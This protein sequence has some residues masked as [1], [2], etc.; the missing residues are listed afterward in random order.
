MESEAPLGPRLPLPPDR[1]QVVILNRIPWAQYDALCRAR[2]DSAGPRMAYLDGRL[3]FISPSR[4]HEYEKKLIAR[5]IETYAEETGLS[6]N[7]FGSETYRRKVKEA[8]V[9]PD[10]CYCVGPAKLVPDFAIAVEYT[11]GGIDKLEI[12]RRLR[13]AE[14]WIWA[15]GRFWIYRLAARRYEERE[16]SEVLPRLD[17]AE[18][19]RIV[20]ST[21]ESHQTEA[22]RAYRRALR[23]R[24]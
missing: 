23:R 1:D 24:G 10:E 13:V 6:L 22:V 12:Y 9:E 15:R 17:L 21:D 2:E 19:A 16:G 18:I 8:G 3:E 11:S 7:G 20:A 14:V 5:L 4:R